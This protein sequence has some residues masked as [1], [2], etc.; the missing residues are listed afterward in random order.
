[1]VEHLAKLPAHW[2]IEV[3]A[4]LEAGI[5]DSSAAGMT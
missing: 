4:T 5:R 2:Q 1:M 3:E